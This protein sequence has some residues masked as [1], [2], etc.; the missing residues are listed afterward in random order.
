MHPAGSAVSLVTLRRLRDQFRALPAQPDPVPPE[1]A[2]RTYIAARVR[3][4]VAYFANEGVMIRGLVL[5][6]DEELTRSLEV[7]LDDSGVGIYGEVDAIPVELMVS[8]DD[9]S[10][11]AGSF[12]LLVDSSEPAVGWL[13][14]VAGMTFPGS[15]SS[16]E[17]HTRW[18]LEQVDGVHA[19]HAAD[20]AHKL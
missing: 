3:E 13:P 11:A 16:D 5:I 4:L 2:E 17:W 9:D 14:A 15:V 7:Q 12:A 19:R 10:I 18:V 20:I 6:A 1:R 8:V